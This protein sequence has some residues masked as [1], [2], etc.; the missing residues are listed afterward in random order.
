FVKKILLR[1]TIFEK[2]GFAYIGPVDGLDFISLE[3]ALNIAKSA[4]RPVLLHVN[5]QKGRGYAPA[6]TE[7]EKYHGVSAF[8]KS[9]GILPAEEKSTFSSEFG[10]ALCDLA[11][12][13]ERICAITAAMTGG[14][15]LSEFAHRFSSRFFDVGIAEGHAVTMAAGLSRGGLIPVFCVYSTF[16]PRAADML[17]HDAALSDEHIVLA[18]DRAGFVPGDGETHQGIFDVGLLASIPNVTVFAPENYNELRKML[19][20]AAFETPGIAVIRYPKGSGTNI[21]LPACTPDRWFTEATVI[22]DENPRVTAVTYGTLT[23]NLCDAADISGVP[24]DIVVLKKIIPLDITP[25]AKSL[26]RTG[27]LLVVEDNFKDIIAQSIVAELAKAGVFPKTVKSISCGGVVPKEGTVQELQ[28]DFGLSAE[29]LAEE[30]QSVC[31]EVH[32]SVGK[33]AR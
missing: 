5:T 12:E 18:V 31:A 8:D 14:T 6:E 9:I 20:I 28:E 24:L 3:N 7:P 32:A 13:D 33:K 29:R 25:I 23:Q 17:I 22:S 10:K 2:M 21:E 16:L 27:K 30:L 15:G 19:K 1:D 4:D 11:A 26:L